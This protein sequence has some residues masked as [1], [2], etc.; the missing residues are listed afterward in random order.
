MTLKPVKEDLHG[1]KHAMMIPFVLESICLLS[2]LFFSLSGCCRALSWHTSTRGTSSKQ[3]VSLSP[4]V[5][6]F[7]LVYF[8][9]PIVFDCRVLKLVRLRPKQETL[10][11]TSRD[12]VPPQDL[13]KFSF[14]LYKK[15][16]LSTNFYIL[17]NFCFI[18]LISI[19][20]LRHYFLVFFSD[21][22]S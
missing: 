17:L 16:A 19:F 14:S 2:C 11:E 8:D 18:F 22:Y 10:S 3:P 5:G 7:T 15:E 4:S 13:H 1:F 20:C 6:L 12:V 9:F 21:V